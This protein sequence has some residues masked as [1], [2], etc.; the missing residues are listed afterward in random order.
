MCA[1]SA[2]FSNHPKLHTEP[3]FLRGEEWASVARDIVLR[4]CQSPNLTII[5]CALIIGLHEFATCHGYRSWLFGGLATRMALLLQLHK[6]LDHDPL[7]QGSPLSFI[8]REIRRR[9]MWSCFLMDQFNSSGH[10]RPPLIREEWLR[11]LPLPVA[12][13]NFQLDMPA[14]TENLCLGQAGSAA[15]PLEDLKTEDGDREDLKNNM[16]VAAYMIKAVA[17]W[18]R[19]M[20]HLNQG[21]KELDPKPMWDNESTHMNLVKLA[22]EM[23]SSLPEALVYNA[24]NLHLH[25]TE[26]M[27]NQFIFL[28]I[29][30]QQNILFLNRFATSSPDAK[31]L[32]DIPKTF[33]TTAGAKAFAAA[34]RISEILRDSEP[35]LVAAPFVG[36]CAFLASTVH[37]FGVF[38]G[39]KTIESNSTKNLGTNIKFLT[40]MKRYWGMFHYLTDDLREQ[41]RTCADAAR[42][43]DF[44]KTD[45]SSPIFQYGDWFDRY[46]N[47]VSLSDFV[48]PAIYKKQEKEEDAVLEQKSELHTVEEFFTALSPQSKTGSVRSNSMSTR[49]KAHAMAAKRAS[50]ASGSSDQHAN[51]QQP[52]RILTDLSPD[53]LTSDRLAQLAQQGRFSNVTLGGQT[54]GATNFSTL[55]GVPHSSGFGTSLS[56]VSPVTL[57]HA[58]F[59]AGHDPHA[60]LYP[61][62]L[63]SF[64]L[65][66]NGMLSTSML[67]PFG[68]ISPAVAAAMMSNDLGGWP[69]S[70]ADGRGENARGGTGASSAADGPHNNPHHTVYGHGHDVQWWNDVSLGLDTP[71]D[72]SGLSRLHGGMD[73]FANLFQSN[74]GTSDGMDGANGH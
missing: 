35:Y 14:S 16:G 36:Y 44:S 13:K 63:M 70:V 58:Q 19:V 56:P 48:D 1:I 30:L 41:Y 15:T 55:A 11:R 25:D 6:D 65:A 39:N 54:S 18:G 37:I 12:E 29:V 74:I 69:D 46:P 67:S 40:K 28:H 27:A 50:I 64:Q 22:E 43:G 20:N 7:R 66:Q 45:A 8:D 2:R 61:H 3:A 24:D 73:G 21:G 62:D 49:R 33:V 17:L 10:D 26:A 68:D 51:L 72:V 47:G 42:R 57:S 32:Q 23:E 59:A 38:S 31:S 60:G 71:S 53:Q 9:T 34:N 5:T 4:R 52:G